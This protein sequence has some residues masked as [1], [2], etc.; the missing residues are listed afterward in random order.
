M[1]AHLA[2]SDGSCAAQS[3]A[4]ARRRRQEGRGRVYHS[5]QEAHDRD[6]SLQHDCA[7]LHR[8]ALG[9]RLGG[10][11]VIK[12]F[13]AFF[14]HRVVLG[15]YEN[16]WKAPKLWIVVSWPSRAARDHWH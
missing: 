12:G 9:L 16:R 4:E 2:R 1:G 14:A 8:F 10:G 6:P 7:A 15:G 3:N 5:H 11:E 13:S